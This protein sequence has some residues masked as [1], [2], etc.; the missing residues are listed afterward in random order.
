MCLH[1]QNDISAHGTMVLTWGK[2]GTL[3]VL[4]LISTLWNP[5]DIFLI[6]R[7]FCPDQRLQV[8]KETTERRWVGLAVYL[9]TNSDDP[10]NVLVRL[11]AKAP[12]KF[13]RSLDSSNLNW[14]SSK[15]PGQPWMLDS[16]DL[17][18]AR[19]RQKGCFQIIRLIQSD[20]NAFV[21][22]YDWM[23]SWLMAR[24]DGDG[25]QRSQVSNF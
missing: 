8:F 19:T 15:R 6:I 5:P 24:G 21:G 14:T 2:T 9:D 23:E 18:S 7:I 13:L 16:R 22:C 1:P 4:S 12:F 11:C 10:E 25:T 3:T 17:S 20:L